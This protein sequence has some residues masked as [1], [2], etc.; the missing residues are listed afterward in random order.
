MGGDRG[1]REIGDL[2]GLADVDAVH[3][4]LARSGLG[5]LGG[6]RLQAALVAVRQRQISAAR[7]KLERQRPADTTGGAGHGGRCSG[8]C[9]H[10]RSTPVMKAAATLIWLR[11]FGKPGAQFIAADL[12]FGKQRPQIK[13]GPGGPLSFK[14][15]FA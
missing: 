1:L 10:V 13:S 5:D 12:T 8:D 4:D 15:H 3:R 7:R 6:D 9:G 11:G 14:N 2:A